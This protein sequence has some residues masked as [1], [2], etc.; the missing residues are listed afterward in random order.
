MESDGIIGMIKLEKF[1]SALGGRLEAVIQKNASSPNVIK[2]EFIL[3]VCLF[4]GN[5]R[6]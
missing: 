5:I 6:L 3:G 2:R 4:F 1:E